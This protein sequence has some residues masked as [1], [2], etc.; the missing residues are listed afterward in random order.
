MG[1]PGRNFDDS[2]VEKF[3]STIRRSGGDLGMDISDVSSR[4]YDNTDMGGIEDYLNECANKSL[5]LLIVVLPR[6]SSSV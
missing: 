3:V 1:R 5:D 6:K 4:P 2:A